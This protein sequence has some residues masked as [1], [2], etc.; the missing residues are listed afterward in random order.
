VNR[1]NI[2][3]A[4]AVIITVLTALTL[5]GTVALDRRDDLWI[6]VVLGV[7]AAW[8]WWKVSYYS[9]SGR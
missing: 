2:E 4:K 5:L 6:A 9:D 7:F 1:R 3:L 8:C